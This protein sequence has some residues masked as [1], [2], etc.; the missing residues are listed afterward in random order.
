MLLGI[1]LTLLIGPA[2]PVPAPPGIAEALQSVQV[3]HADEG[4]SG[5]QL[6]FEMGRGGPT[7]IVDY[8]P[9]L[10]P[11]LRP[12]SRVVLIAHFNL[13]PHVL[14]DGIVT[15][16]Q[17]APGSEPGAATLTLTG[18]DVSVMMDLEQKRAEHPA[19]DETLIALKIIAS[20]ALYGLVPDVRPPPV[21]DVPVPIDRVPAQQDTDLEYLKAMASRHGYVFFIE[22]GPLPLMNTAYWGPPKRLGIPQPALSVNMGPQTNVETISFQYN[23]LAPTMVMDSVQ[24]ADLNVKL[25]VV[26]FMG[27]RPPLV[28]MP[29]LPFNLPNVKRSL[30]SDS[31]GLKITQ[32]YARAQ[33][34]TDKSLDAVVTATGSL[35]ALRYGGLLKPRG[36]V[37][38]RGAGFTHD[39]LYYVKNVSHAISRGGYKQNFTLTREGDGAL[40]PVV[41]P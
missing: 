35:D 21:V 15:T 29:A 12:F 16:R 19:Q 37:G 36:L 39:G 6:V 41:R 30:L 17:V 26:T 31:S 22:P 4:R 25:P 13:V 34:I 27:T 2:V 32:A 33:A 24:D 7:D 40:M 18:E 10:S 9:L 11:L 5:F 14:M 20:Y 3:T 8:P 38:L 23:A 28:P 1:H